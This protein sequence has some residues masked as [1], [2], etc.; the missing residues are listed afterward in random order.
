MPSYLGLGDSGYDFT[1]LYTCFTDRC[2]R[3][4][5]VL[6]L[7]IPPATAAVLTVLTLH[8]KR[9]SPLN[10]S[11]QFSLRLAC[12]SFGLL[13]RTYAATRRTAPAMEFGAANFMLLLQRLYFL[14]L[15]ARTFTDTLCYVKSRA[16][17][18]QRH[19]WMVVPQK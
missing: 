3:H 5:G 15:P 4:R 9:I 18:S 10:L 12:F 17:R 16:T 2:P 13:R 19:T 14:L 1:P 8:C 11:E 6:A 7:V